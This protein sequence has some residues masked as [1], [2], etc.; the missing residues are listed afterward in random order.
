MSF[1]DTAKEKATQLANTAKVKVD[2]FT[3]KRKTDHLL[4]ELGRIVYRQH[5]GDTAP[6]DAAEI[7]KLVAELRGLEDDDA[8]I[9]SHDQDPADATPAPPESFSPSTTTT[10]T[11]PPPTP[12][13]SNS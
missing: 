10:S 13:V 2:D 1:L 5:T 9:P 4:G 7:A 6:G 12:P 3:D 8:A 11:M